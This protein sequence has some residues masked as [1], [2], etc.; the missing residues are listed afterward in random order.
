[1]LFLADMLRPGGCL[2]L[3]D[4]ELLSSPEFH[5]VAPRTKIFFKRGI[6]A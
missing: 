5:E 4:A 3:G 6:S 2:V 1:L